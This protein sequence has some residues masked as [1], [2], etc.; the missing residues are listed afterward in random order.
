MRLTSGFP[1]LQGLVTVFAISIALVPSLLML[2]RL[3]AA[4]SYATVT[5]QS[6]Y[7]LVEEQADLMATGNKPNVPFAELS[8]SWLSLCLG[9]LAD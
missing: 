4:R 9:R 6:A 5:L 7:M 3:M 8:V 1:W 2:M